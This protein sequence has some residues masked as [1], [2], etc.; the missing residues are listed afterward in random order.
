VQRHGGGSRVALVQADLL[1][2]VPGPFEMVVS[3]PPY[4]G[5]DERE[6]LMPDVRQYEPAL[7]LFGGREGTDAIARLVRQAADRL[8]PGGSLLLEIA[9]ARCAEVMEMIRSAE[10]W[11]DLS[12]RDDYA[13]LPRIVRARRHAA[14]PSP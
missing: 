11:D 4:V 8:V 5:L 2:G 13:G 7:A 9:S 12:V 10:I 6:S 3:N 14:S 1:E